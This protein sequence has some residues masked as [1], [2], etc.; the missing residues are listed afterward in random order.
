M[1]GAPALPPSPPACTCATLRRFS[2]RLSAIYD[3]HLAAAGLTTNQYSLLMTLH[4][5]GPSPLGRLARRAAMDRTTLTRLIA[6]L[7]RAGWVESRPGT[8]PRQRILALTGTGRDRLAAAQPHW[9]AAQDRIE[10]ALGADSVGQLHAAVAQ[11]M[12]RLRA[13]LPSG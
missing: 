9:R 7:A 10:T 8:D 2:R 6:P 4:V 3:R 5:A 1:N 11:A 12:P 13:L